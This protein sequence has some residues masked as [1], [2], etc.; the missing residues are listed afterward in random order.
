MAMSAPVATL[1][2]DR[3]GT[4]VEEPPDE[5]VDSLEKIRFLPGVFAAL[6]DLKRRGYRFVMVTNQDGLGT[7][8]FPQPDVRQAARIHSGGVSLPGHRVRPDLRVPAFQGRQL[9]LSEAENGSGGAIHA[10]RLG[11][12]RR[13]CGHWR[14]GHRPGIRDESRHTRHTSPSARD[15]R[16]DLAGRSFE[17]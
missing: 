13:Q 7:A 1:F 15:R 3:D 6:N 9:L 10:R 2:I 16:R 17:H 8:S 14:S 11:G 12:P 5:Q 4:L